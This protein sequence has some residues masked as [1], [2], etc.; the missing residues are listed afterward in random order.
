[1]WCSGNERSA[2]SSAEPRCAPA[3]LVPGQASLLSVLCLGTI[4]ALCFLLTFFI[5]WLF[6]WFLFAFYP[7]NVPLLFFFFFASI[8]SLSAVTGCSPTFQVGMVFWAVK[9]SYF[10]PIPFSKPLLLWLRTSLESWACALVYAHTK[11]LH[12]AEFPF[13]SAGC[14]SMCERVLEIS[15]GITQGSR[16]APW[17]SVP[18]PGGWR[19]TDTAQTPSTAVLSLPGIGGE[20]LS[21]AS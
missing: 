15:S 21:R 18:V 1:M 20:I 16:S 4:K 9:P 3:S 17:V 7:I 13:I 11:C 5:A 14:S 8:V 10:S 6:F 19:C 2:G 12:L